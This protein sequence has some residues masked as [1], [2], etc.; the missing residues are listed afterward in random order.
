MSI[1]EIVYGPTMDSR[2]PM[3]ALCLGAMLVLT[4]SAAWA[5]EPA[6]TAKNWRKHPSIVAVRALYTENEKLERER[7]LKAERLEISCDG[8]G[9]ETERVALRDET[10]HIRQYLLGLGGEDSGYTVE[11]HYDAQ[12]RLRFL[13]AKGG[14]VNGSAM[15]LRIYFDEG[16]QRL[17][18]DRK[19]VKGPGYTFINP[20]PDEL[21]VRDAEKA[22]KASPGPGCETQ[23]KGAP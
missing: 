14:A 23:T 7:K 18:E 1:E 11:H 3:R 4:A 9:M 8:P 20:W 17:W 6:I 22:F 5:G 13:F 19:R 2:K 12:G 15:E 10:G 21:L 16:G